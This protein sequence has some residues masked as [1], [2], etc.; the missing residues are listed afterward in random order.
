MLRAPEAF[1]VPAGLRPSQ[2]ACI[3]LGAVGAKTALLAVCEGDVREV[4]RARSA[5]DRGAAKRFAERVT[6]RALEGAEDGTLG[7][8]PF[9]SRPTKEGT[10]S[11]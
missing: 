5:L 8:L 1:A 11:S 7:I 2:A 3:V 6:G 9:R 10:V 4:L